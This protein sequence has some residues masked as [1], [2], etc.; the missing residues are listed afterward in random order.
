M[1]QGK[2]M[3]ATIGG[4]VRGAGGAIGSA[5]TGGYGRTVQG[6]AIGGA[7]GGAYGMMSGDTSML[8][9]AF[10]GAAL[11]AGGARYLGAGFKRAGIG[12]VGRRTRGMGTMDHARAYGG[13]FMRGM[14]RQARLDYRGARM[15]T[16][17]AG[18]YIK[19]LP[20]MYGP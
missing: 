2:G 16:N 10:G 4:Y 14:Y 18:N 13:A 6:A 9:G 12:A 19:G 5:F 11:G 17:R 8:G 20:F 1:P 3:F 7:M 15:A